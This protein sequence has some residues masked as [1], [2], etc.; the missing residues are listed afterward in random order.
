HENLRERMVFG[1]SR[2]ISNEYPKG[3]KYWD[4][5]LPEVIFIGVLEFR[6]DADE[7]TQYLKYVKLIEEQTSKVFYSKWTYIFLEPRKG[8]YQTY[9]SRQVSDK[10][11]NIAKH[12]AEITSDIDRWFW[13]LNNLSRADK[14]PA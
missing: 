13:L 9:K 5:E 11:P 8:L 1:A 7:R 12:D 3:A 14:I 6:L 2:L 4:F 10:I